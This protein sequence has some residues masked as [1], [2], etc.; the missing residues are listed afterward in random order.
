MISDIT[1]PKRSAEHA[2]YQIE[3]E[4][5]LD[6]PIRG[7]VDAAIQAGWSPLANDK[8]VQSVAVNQGP[9]RL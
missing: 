9:L 5:A 7:L 3:L 1:S 8:A 4:E 6:I 2:D